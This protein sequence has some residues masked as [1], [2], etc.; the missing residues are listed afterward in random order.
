MGPHN[1]QKC[2]DVTKE[3]LLRVFDD[4]LKHKVDLKG[5]CLKPNM[6]V[7]GSAAS[8]KSAPQEIAEMTVSC[9]MDCVPRKYLELYFYLAV[10]QKLKQLKI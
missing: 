9:F 10:N 8:K 2:Y 1:I 7:D 3:T 6:I 4:L 5:I